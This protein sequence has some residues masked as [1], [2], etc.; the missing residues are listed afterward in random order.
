MPSRELGSPFEAPNGAQGVGTTLLKRHKILPH[1]REGRPSNADS[2]SVPRS[3]KSR[4]ASTDSRTTSQSVPTSDNSNPRML[5]HTSKR[6]GAPLLPPTP[7]AHSR[8]SSGNSNVLVIPAPPNGEVA[9]VRDSDVQSTPSTPTVQK[10]PPTPDVTPP[11][12]MPPLTFRPAVTNSR[13][14]SSRTDSFRTAPE[15]LSSDE[16]ES[17]T[18]RPRIPSAKPSD[19]EVLQTSRREVGLGLGLESDNEGSATPRAKK[20]SPQ[21]EF[22]AFDGEWGNP[23]EDVSEVEREW[24][25][26]LMRNVT[27]RKRHDRDMIFDEEGAN[28]EV[29]EDD[30]ISPAKAT[31]VLRGLPLQDNVEHRPWEE[32]SVESNLRSGTWPR[33]RKDITESPIMADTRRFSTISGHSTTSTVVE[34]FVVEVP[35]SRMRTLRH[36]KKQ[37]GLRDFSS[38]STLSSAPPSEKSSEQ[39]HRLVHKAE[40]IP[41]RHDGSLKSTTTPSVTSS[42]K[43]RRKIIRE[44]GVPVVV[45]PDRISSAKSSKPPSLR[46]TSSRKTKRSNSLQS[47]PLSQSSRTNEPGYFDFIPPTRKRTMSESAGSSN[48]VRTIDYPPSIP[49]RK[50]SLSAPTSRNTSRAGSLTA[51]SLKAHNMLQQK[52]S[53][54]QEPVELSR[55]ISSENENGPSNARSSIDQNRSSIDHHDERQFQARRSAQATPFSQASYETTGTAATSAEI[56]QAMAVS[57]VPHQN[58]SWTVIQRESSEPSS[59][60][61]RRLIP[62]PTVEV[63]DT[64]ADMP[65]TPPQNQHTMV[66]VESPLR[67]PRSPPEP[68]A[69]KF[70]PPTPSDMSPGT[71]EERQLGFDFDTRLDEEYDDRPSS[72]DRNKRNFSLRRAFSNRRHSETIVPDTGLLKRKF[73][74]S[75]RRKH[76]STQTSKPE[77][78]P[79]THYP[80]VLDQ[81]ADDSKLHPFWRPANFWDDLEDI[82]NDSDEDEEDYFPE[83]H[84]PGNRRIIAKRG[85]SGKLKRTFAILP[86]SYGNDDYVQAPLDRKTIRRSPSGNALRVVKQRSNNTLRREAD[87]RVLREARPGEFGHGF[88][89]GNG[90]RIHTI[91]GLGLRIEY[92]GL[93]GLGKKL[94]ER[95]KEQRNAKL[96]ATISGPKEL[97]NGVDEVLESRSAESWNVI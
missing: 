92:V 88:K 72:S 87:Q 82:E 77:A 70:I 58:R 56:S 7:P 15:N 51:E 86:L 26:N 96:R 61:L 12:A 68:P 90:G 4:D 91:P 80:S 95:R 71:A 23:L 39:Y 8:Q 79:S 73:S 1:P 18:V 10:S 59:P 66:E 6:I 38:K 93:R 50:S 65:V 27:V 20:V 34:A 11:R 36:T 19:A 5:K 62:Q 42:H 44:G 46:S 41:E 63:N 33:V 76:S 67:N 53:P 97:R 48:S 64:T 74:L 45:I 54:K 16:D 69:I 35:P 49:T 25:D 2:Y 24:D 21:L 40:R 17:S 78:N 81:P 75:G 57:M 30:H 22:S 9:S 43:S 55:P 28:K 37:I 60:T 14:P 94:S 31:Q 84:S 32:D 47:A 85:L 89:E 3:L 13:H 83:Y 52:Q 29:V